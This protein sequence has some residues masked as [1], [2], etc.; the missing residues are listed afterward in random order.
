MPRG[1][2][3]IIHHA[4]IGLVGIRYRAKG[5]GE[6]KFRLGCGMYVVE[7][8]RVLSEPAEIMVEGELG[9]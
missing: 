5:E 7:N 3:C 6:R 2:V 1:P 4:R 8:R 9:V